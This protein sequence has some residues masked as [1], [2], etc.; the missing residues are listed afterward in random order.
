[1]LNI[2]IFSDFACPFC[3]I[4]T[5]VI[6]NLEED[7]VSFSVEWIPY[8]MYPDIPLEGRSVEDKHPRDYHKKMVEFQNNLGSEYGIKYKKQE[9]DY[10]THRALLAGEYAKSVGKYNKFSKEAFRTYFYDLRNLGDK[11]VLD[12]IAIKAHIDPVD[13]NSLID[14]GEFNKNMEEAKRLTNKFEVEGTPTFIINDEHKM[15]GVRPY[16]QMKR[17]FLAFG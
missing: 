17:S 11:K 3:Y 7:G 13:M 5:G 4:A 16:H 1:M 2:K 12:D 10:N 14:S 6:D 9:M 8:E 15:V